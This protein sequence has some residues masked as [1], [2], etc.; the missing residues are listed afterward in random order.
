MSHGV[1]R[2]STGKKTLDL[3]A[4]ESASASGGPRRSAAS[5]TSGA[6]S[7][8]APAR[9]VELSVDRRRAPLGLP[10]ENI[11]LFS[12]KIRRGC[13]R[14]Q[15]ELLRIVRHIAP[16]LLSP[17]ASTKVMNEGTATYVHYRI[18]NRLHQQG[19][20]SDG[21]FLE[22]LQSPTTVVFQ[23]GFDDQRFSGSTRMRWASR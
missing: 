21:N 6:L 2:S 22:F 7:Q 16:V 17:R 10:Q 20:I 9:L 3:R 13:N 4:E 11:L 19:R 15:R 14:W 8:P 12:R 23:P 18:M 1:F 5:T